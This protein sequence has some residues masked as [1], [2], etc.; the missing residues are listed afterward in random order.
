MIGVTELRSGTIFE[1][2]GNIFQV[3]SYEHIK[4]GRGS[5]NIKVKVKNLRS[6]ATTEKSF[7]SG[8]RVSE[9]YVSKKDLQY[10]YK[11]EDF[12]YLMDPESFEQ[13]SVSTKILGSDSHY[14][15]EGE[16]FNVSFLENEP[17]SVNLPPKMKF[18]VIEAGAGV[19]GNSATNIFKEVTLENGLKTKVPLFINAGMDV[20]IDTRTGEYT[21]KK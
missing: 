1:D 2:N 8:A 5:A 19:K 20:I 11:D 3:L 9:I 6:G 4:M 13:I 15:K 12:A 21:A 7:I 10:L 14:L 18:K 17:L 16:S